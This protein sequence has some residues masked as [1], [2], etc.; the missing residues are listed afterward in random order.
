MVVDLRE[1]TLRRADIRLN[2]LH[3]GN[4]RARG[5][6]IL[7]LPHRAMDRYDFLA[8]CGIMVIVLYFETM[9]FVM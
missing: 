3:M 8:V 5:D 9:Q 2:S 1:D 4:L 6:I 7:Q